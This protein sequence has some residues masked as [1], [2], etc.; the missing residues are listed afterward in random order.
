M[1]AAKGAW[2]IHVIMLSSTSYIYNYIVTTPPAVWF[3]SLSYSSYFLSHSQA[4]QTTFHFT[5][6]K[7]PEENYHKLLSISLCMS[8]P[9][10]S[11]N[12]FFCGVTGK[13]IQSVHTWKILLGRWEIIHPGDIAGR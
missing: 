2:E 1:L 3:H 4:P 9:V 12:A 8:D 11:E 6:K 5:K 7:A 13:E 10:A